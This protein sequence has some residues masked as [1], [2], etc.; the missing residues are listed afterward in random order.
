MPQARDY[1]TLEAVDSGGVFDR[2]TSF[3]LRNTMIG[4]SHASF[5][6]GDSGTFNA[7][8]EITQLGTRWKVSVNGKPRLGGKVHTRQAP[9]DAQRA[10]VV[11]LIV[12]TFLSEAMVVSA[13]PTVKV[14]N[15]SIK[16]FILAVYLTIGATADDF[17][18]AADVARDLITGR[19]TKGGRSP[20]DLEPIQEPQAR[21]R[22]PETIHAAVDRHLRRHGFMHWDGPDG[23]I[24]VGEPDDEQD[25]LY[26]FRMRRGAA[27]A[28]NNVLSI[29][30]TQDVGTAATQLGVYGIG[31]GT[32]FS[33]AQVNGQDVNESLLD[34]GFIRPVL[35]IDESIRTEELAVRRARREMGQRSRTLD[36]FQIECD[37]L[38]FRDGKTLIPY[39][40]DTVCDITSELHGGDLGRY[41]VEATQL[42]LDPHMGAKSTLTIVP[43]GSWRL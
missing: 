12:R 14:E 43:P 2:F 31:G 9:A 4:G 40:P 34:L 7:L 30:R 20:R 23:K 8:Q 13:E 6:V 25:P 11:Q 1:V 17:V 27:A 35:I 22:P 38:S 37:G 15:T 16:D 29:N 33:K 19:T 42:R 36:A 28:V 39:A 32:E 3:E 5:E 21:V 10:S 41:Y 26:F 18:F 24:V